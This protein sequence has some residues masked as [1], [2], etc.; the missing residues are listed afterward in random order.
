[1]HDQNH[2][3]HQS[4]LKLGVT[5]EHVATQG[6]P[7]SSSSVA[8]SYRPTFCGLGLWHTAWLLLT[9]SSW[10]LS[11][12]RRA[13]DR[14]WP[15][16]SPRSWLICSLIGPDG[17]GGVASGTGKLPAREHPSSQRSLRLVACANGQ[18]LW[19]PFDLFWNIC[20]WAGKFPAAKHAGCSGQRRCWCGE[21]YTGWVA[22]VGLGACG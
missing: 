7:E 2:L 20:R 8:P 10:A 19:R 6:T 12:V 3:Q 18:Q 22:R 14:Y 17:P 15:T 1:M 9:P 11:G 5:C 16:R 4:H 13:R 21:L